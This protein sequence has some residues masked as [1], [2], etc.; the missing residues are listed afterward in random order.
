MGDAGRFPRV[1]MA[2]A[3]EDA[4]PAY[5]SFCGL[6]R[7]R[8]PTLNLLFEQARMASER[9]GD[10]VMRDAFAGALIWALHGMLRQYWETAGASKA[11]W[12]RAGPLIT[13]YSVGQI[14]SAALDNVRH[15]EDWDTEKSAALLDRRN[16]RILCM[17]LG[18]PAKKSA[19]HP[20]FRGNVSWALLGAL[21]QST[22]Y[23]AIESLVREFARHLIG[24]A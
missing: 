13:G 11:E 23:G 7:S 12:R 4:A 10:T 17:V 15:F 16:V 2:V 21:S 19:K 18:L 3:L 24:T 20:P 5:E 9:E 8:G 22:G 6:L 1:S 14:L